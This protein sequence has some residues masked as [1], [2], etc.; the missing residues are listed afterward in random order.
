[1]V[2]DENFVSIIILNY[3]DSEHIQN[4]IT[5]V[6]KTIGCKFEI[7]LIDNGSSDESSNICKE[8]YPER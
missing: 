6:F 8:K 4:C 7:I 1:M 5:S 2:S 3:N